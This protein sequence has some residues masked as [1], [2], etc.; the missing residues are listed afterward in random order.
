MPSYV[1]LLVAF[2][3]YDFFIM[4]A[5]S[6]VESQ[7]QFRHQH[8]LSAD[9]SLGGCN[10]TAKTGLIRQEP[11]RTESLLY[12]STCKFF[13][14]ASEEILRFLATYLNGNENVK[15]CL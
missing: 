6:V 4:I 13:I 14:T 1:N 2:V 10:E 7:N 8:D 15:K 5:Q 9:S 11:A 3:L 12:T